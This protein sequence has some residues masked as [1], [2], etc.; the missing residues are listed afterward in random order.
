MRST[1]P[2]EDI[3][4]RRKV[5]EKWQP[6]LDKLLKKHGVN[7]AMFC[8]KHGIHLAWLSRA[9]NQKPLPEWKSINRIEEAFEKEGV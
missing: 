9:K 6:R 2:I 1:D 3:K 5:V 7:S 4:N 8:L